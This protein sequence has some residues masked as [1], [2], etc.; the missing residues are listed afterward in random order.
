MEIMGYNLVS[1]SF[2]EGHT[3][4]VVIDEKETEAVVVEADTAEGGDARS[5]IYTKVNCQHFIFACCILKKV[6]VDILFKK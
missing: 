5:G 4:N 1:Q 2:R 3:F 6:S